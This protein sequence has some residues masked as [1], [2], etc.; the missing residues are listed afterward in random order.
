[1]RAGASSRLRQRPARRRGPARRPTARS[2]RRGLVVVGRP[3]GPRRADAPCARHPRRRR[4]R[5]ASRV[6][7]RAAATRADR[8]PGRARASRRQLAPRAVGDPPL[9]HGLRRRTGAPRRRR[10]P[11]RPGPSAATAAAGTTGGRR[12]GARRPPRCRPP[13]RPGPGAGHTRS[14]GS[15]VARCRSRTPPAPTPC[16]DAPARSSGL[17]HRRPCGRRPPRAGRPGRGRCSRPPKVSITTESVG[18]KP[19]TTGTTASRSSG[20][21]AVQ[22][23]GHDDGRVPAS[24]DDVGPA[25][26]ARCGEAVRRRG[27]WTVGGPLTAVRTRY[28]AR[29]RPVASVLHLDLDAFFAAVEQRDK[30]SLRG[31][32]VVVGGVGGRGRGGDRVLRGPAST[33]SARPCR[34]ARPGRAART[35]RSCP[36]ASTPTA[37]ASADGDGAAARRSPRWSSRSPSTRPS[38]TSSG[39]TCP[40]YDVET[41]TA[42][43][44]ASCGRGSP[45]SPAG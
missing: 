39:P 3:P 16:R 20:L 28:V 17:D 13:G 45:R 38:S 34:P 2:S 32:P 30:P 26:R 24:A 43:R 5:G 37:E 14:A 36:A 7:A 33:A 11:P 31:K 41:V 12:P 6:A 27:L 22:R 18:T 15:G 23:G 42:L 4:R 25:R 19:S 35:R 29:M 40:T 44:R 8:A 1:M 9:E 10:A 21:R